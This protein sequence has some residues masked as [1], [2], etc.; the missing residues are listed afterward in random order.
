MAGV[1]EVEVDG[2]EHDHGV[3]HHNEP[4]Q[5][6]VVGHIDVYW[7]MK[8]MGVSLYWG[9]RCQLEILF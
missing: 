6:R 4:N 1:F 8:Q 3:E 9:A 2:V 7:Q 5:V